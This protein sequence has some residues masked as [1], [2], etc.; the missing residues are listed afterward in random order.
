M[1][2]DSNR[3]DFNVKSEGNMDDEVLFRTFEKQIHDKEEKYSEVQSAKMT[4]SDFLKQ[5]PINRRNNSIVMVMWDDLCVYT[6]IG[7]VLYLKEKYKLKDVIIVEELYF[8]RSPIYLDPVKFAYAYINEQLSED[9]IKKE[10]KDNYMTIMEYSPVS[11]TL[12][13]ILNLI[14]Y[15]TSITFVFRHDTKEIPSLLSDFVH[16][17]KVVK[18]KG[19]E[20][21]YVVLDEYS[22]TKIMLHLKPNNVF[23]NDVAEVFEII[24]DNDPLEDVQIYGPVVHNNLPSE[25]KEL[26][27]DKLEGKILPKRCCIT[28]YEERIYSSPGVGTSAVSERVG[29]KCHPIR[30]KVSE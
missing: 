30:P 6:G 8:N 2:L 12:M 24:L 18:G 19:C 28:F 9:V 10:L 29:D 4:K 20:L 5:F 14:N 23:C 22:L 15:I 1:I 7:L 27:F 16:M 25:F 26:Y 21:N 3:L 17:F 13:A 11:N